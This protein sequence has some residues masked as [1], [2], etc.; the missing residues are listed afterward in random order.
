MIAYTRRRKVNPSDTNVK[1]SFTDAN[2][3]A[4]EEYQ[5]LHPKFKLWAEI[6]GY[7]A[8]NLKYMK[9]DELNKLIEKSPYYKAT[10]HD[11]DWI[12]KV[13]L[14]GAVQKWVDHSISVTVNIPENVTEEVVSTIYQT[15]WG[16]GCKGMTIYREGSRDGVLVKSK[17]KNTS[18]KIDFFENNAPKRPEKIEADVVRFKNKDEEWIAVVGLYERR[19]YEIFTG[20]SDGFLLHPAV[21]K[22]WVMRV[23]PQKTELARYDF[24]FV[25]EAGYE[26]TIQGLSR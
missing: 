6:N 25:D 13:Q 15:A 5:I 24:V 20:K 23:K 12:M 7:D 17:E 11:I 3:D 18:G 14:Q 10:A 2:G 19:P 4:F 8:E 1:V 26:Y 22:G 9:I 21:K 16:S